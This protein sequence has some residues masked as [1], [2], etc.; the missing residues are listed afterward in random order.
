MPPAKPPSPARYSPRNPLTGDDAVGLGHGIG[1]RVV[2]LAEP[3][4]GL[5]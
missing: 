2:K 5:G 3:G 1:H 4:A